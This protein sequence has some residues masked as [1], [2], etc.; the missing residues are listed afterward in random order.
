MTITTANICFEIFKANLFGMQRWTHMHGG[1]KSN[2]VL[3]ANS[4][5]AGE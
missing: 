1:E 4:G 3:L 2:L 5:S